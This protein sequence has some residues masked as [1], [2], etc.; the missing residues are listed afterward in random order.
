MMSCMTGKFL[1]RSIAVA[2]AAALAL[3]ASGHRPDVQ[4]RSVTGPCQ[5]INELRPGIDPGGGNR[6]LFALATEYGETQ[7]VITSCARGPLGYAEEWRAEGFAGKNGFAKPG[8][9]LINSLQTPSGAYSISEAFGRSDPGTM[10]PYH[11]V[12][13]DS[14]WGGSAGENF[15][16]YFQGAGVWP[17]EPLWTYMESGMYEQAAVINYNRPPDMD[18]VP[19]RTFAIF[20]HAGSAE[21]WGCI[22]TDLDTVTRVLQGAKPGDHIIMGVESEMFAAP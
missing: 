18:A 22:S 13:K 6:L 4:D 21:T 16:N 8:P 15:N 20:L 3:T 2:S 19:G 12:G 7:V 11:Q 10:L 9:V 1:L 17:D 14:Y 5:R